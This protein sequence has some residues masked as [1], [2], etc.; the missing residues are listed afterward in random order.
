M[1]PIMILFLGCFVGA[2]LFA[3]NPEKGFLRRLRKHL[4]PCNP[5]ALFSLSVIA[6]AGVYIYEFISALYFGGLTGLAFENFS[7]YV[8]ELFVIWGISNVVF[9][10]TGG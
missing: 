10:F 3:M 9:R 1:T 4:Q 6:I 8:K 7:N 2:I 5:C